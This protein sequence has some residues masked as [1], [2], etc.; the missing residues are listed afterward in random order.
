MSF[1]AQPSTETLGFN[2]EVKLLFTTGDLLQFCQF[3]TYGVSSILFRYQS[4]L[5]EII[6]IKTQMPHKLPHW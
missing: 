6:S 5:F 4:I 2:P 1:I 3:H